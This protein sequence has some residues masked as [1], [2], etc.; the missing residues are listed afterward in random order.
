MLGAVSLKKTCGF[1]YVNYLLYLCRPI[2]YFTNTDLKMNTI[3]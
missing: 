2:E 3:V 1:V